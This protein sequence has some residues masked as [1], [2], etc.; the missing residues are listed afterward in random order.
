MF[1]GIVLMNAD[2]SD[3]VLLT[4]P[5]N[6][7]CW[8]SDENPYFTPDGTQIVFGRENWATET[9]DIYIMNAD[10]RGVTN[11]TDGVGYNNDPIVV[12]DSSTSAKRILF[13]SNRD[14]LTT[15]GS[16]F[17]L[18]VM[19]LDGTGLSQLTYNSV[20]DGFNLEFMEE[21]SVSAVRRMQPRHE[22]RAM[23]QPAQRLRW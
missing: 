9:E 4:N 14:Q 1:D 11:L 22:P 2:G 16:G 23:T 6:T 3:P 15:G 13:S 5:Y 7:D 18:Y 19:N 8:C 10:G 20:Y 12:V 21:Q 17:E